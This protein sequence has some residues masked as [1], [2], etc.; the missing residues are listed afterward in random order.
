MNLGAE[1]YRII[2]EL[3]EKPAEIIETICEDLANYEAAR[4]M[5]IAKV[6]VFQG[7]RQVFPE[8]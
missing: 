4:F 7:A 3:P 1:M 6:T 5:P 8:V 2:I